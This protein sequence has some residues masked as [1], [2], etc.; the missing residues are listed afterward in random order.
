MD[1]GV[2]RG[3]RIYYDTVYPHGFPTNHWRVPAPCNA[4]F[5][6]LAVKNLTTS[7]SQEVYLIGIT[8][9]NGSQIIRY[10]F[11]ERTTR[12]PTPYE[13]T[14]DFT[15]KSGEIKQFCAIY[16]ATTDGYDSEE[17][18]DNFDFEEEDEEEDEEAEAEVKEE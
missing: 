1:H 17:D 16:Y 12:T 9:K 4:K 11:L 10:R 6:A 13:L 14:A 3:G 8:T 7:N 15:L 5:Q 2:C 18:C